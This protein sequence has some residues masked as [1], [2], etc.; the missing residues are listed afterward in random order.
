MAINNNSTPN[1]NSNTSN[2]TNSS[3]RANSNRKPNPKKR[4]TSNDKNSSTNKSN[5]SNP[6]KNNPSNGSNKNP[7]QNSNNNSNTNSN[8]KRP[9][10]NWRRKPRRKKNTENSKNNNNSNNNT[11]SNS[12]LP[13][14]KGEKKQK[15]NH[16]KIVNVGRVLN[17]ITKQLQNDIKDLKDNTKECV[18]CKKK[19]DDMLTALKLGDERFC[20]FQCAQDKILEK[21]EL[22]SNE[23]LTYIGNGDFSVMQKRN[24]RGKNYLFMKKRINRDEQEF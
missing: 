5:R 7:N 9:N 11:K 14:K 13:P 2:K 10:R 23:T 4:T 20:H 17:D 3:N 16:Y 12:L 8:K 24:N 1:N 15:I 18:L 22:K 21:E 6:Q 19:I